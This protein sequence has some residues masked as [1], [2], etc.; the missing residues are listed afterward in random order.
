M[1]IIFTGA[2]EVFKQIRRLFFF[3]FLKIIINIQ[4]F[5]VE[6][7]R[8]VQNQSRMLQF[9]RFPILILLLIAG[10]S[11][12]QPRQ[13][14]FPGLEGEQLAGALGRYKPE[15]V[16]SYAQAKDVLY[17]QVGHLVGWRV[18]CAYSGY[19]ILPRP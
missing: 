4:T 13:V 18:L 6:C 19:G 12:A 16:L 1:G 8:V 17:S 9:R 15:P 3:K 2:G 7:R 5:P 11:S 10:I 14:L